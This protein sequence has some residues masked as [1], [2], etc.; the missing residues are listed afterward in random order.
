MSSSLESIINNTPL[1][2]VIINPNSR[3]VIIT[4]W[5]GRGNLNKNT[6]VPC[7]EDVGPSGSL[8][9]PPIKYDAM[10]DQW[11]A[12]CRTAKCN[13]LV[14][15]YPQFG[16]PGKYQLAINAKPLFIRKA[17]EACEGRGVVY[18]DGDMTVNKYP[19]I[20]DIPNVDFMARGWNIDP[21]ANSKYR[22]APCFDPT[23][24]ET[25]GGTMYFGNT[26]TARDLL[27][28]WHKSSSKSMF[29]GKAD[30]RIL[31]MLF[32]MKSLMLP[33]NI[34]QLPIEYL[35][36]TQAYTP[37]NEPTYLA[38][39]DW[40]RKAIIF[41]HPACLTTEERAADQG[42]AQ[43]RQP[44]FYQ[45]LVEENILCENGGYTF[46]EFVFFPQKQLV[47]T[48]QPYLDY[49]S[50]SILFHDNNADEDV[51]I[52][53]NIPF[54]QKY[55]KHTMIGKGNIQRVQHI[56]KSL[57]YSDASDV[58]HVV[59]S[60]KESPS[61]RTSPT[62]P[63]G[64]AWHVSSKDVIPAILTCLSKNKHVIYMPSGS[65]LEQY[66]A[67]VAAS[68]EPEIEFIAWQESEKDLRPKFVFNAP[69]YFGLG[70]VV[71]FHLLCMCGT[72]SDIEHRFNSSFIFPSRIRCKWMEE[73]TGMRSKQSQQTKIHTMIQQWRAK[74]TQATAQKSK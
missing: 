51:N 9:R 63:N 58:M 27:D 34:I 10:I 37:S 25:S 36:L 65:S 7:P 40:N 1:T 53:Y 26:K 56:M 45:E 68:R 8:T 54:D 73:G 21:R 72:M 29:K 69:M 59:E 24:F 35:W 33:I 64:N 13:Y 71:L 67:I 14:Q 11:I 44:K 22:T 2:P 15:E 4:Y 66:K 32:G 49:I 55:G 42:A 60:L 52:V 23:I 12:R 43:D 39:T 19:A 3:F 6:Q 70:N 47:A 16:D 50:R 28:L 5:W 46:Y 31:S 17:L 74:K 38:P 20:F 62:A 18:I 57:T 41:E 61:Q 30:D 48:F